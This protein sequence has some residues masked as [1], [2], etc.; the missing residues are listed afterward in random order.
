[1]TGNACADCA[2]NRAPDDRPGGCADGTPHGEWT[3]A[4]CGRQSGG[5][6]RGG[7]MIELAWLAEAGYPFAANDLTYEE[8]IGLGFARRLLK[9]QNGKPVN[10][11]M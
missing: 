1:M 11:K 7:M 5:G 10:S 9:A 8:W 4:N 2:E 6:G 3:R